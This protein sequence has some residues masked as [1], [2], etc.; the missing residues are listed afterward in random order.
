MQSLSPAFD[1]RR[2]WTVKV[3][4]ICLL[5]LLL[6]AIYWALDTHGSFSF[7]ERPGFLNYNML[8][9]SLL[10]GQVHLRQEVHPGRLKERDQANPT[11]PYPYMFDAIVFQ[12]KYYLHHLPFPALIHASW[13]A[14]AGYPLATGFMVVL[15]A[16]GC[17]VWLGLI[18]W[19]IR[20]TFFEQSPAWIL[21]FVL[22][23]FA[24]SGVQLYM[25]SR[26]VIYHEAIATG[27]FLALGGVA[28]C[29]LIMTSPSVNNLMACIAGLL[30]GA[31]IACRA[32]LVFYPL[33]FAAC[34]TAD[35]ILR[36]RTPAT[37]FKQ[38][39]SLLAPVAVSVGLLLLYNH[40][41]FGDFFYSGLRHVALPF[42]KVY[43]YCCL[44][45]NYFRLAHVPYHLYY[46]L[47]GVPDVALWGWFPYLS[48]PLDATV[49]NEVMVLREKV[50]S[51]FLLTP[52]LL[53]ILP[54]PGLLQHT[55]AGRHLI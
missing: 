19:R 10:A 49:L 50:G 4:W 20:Q 52:V 34:L 35:S 22:A 53:L 55:R 39:C 38:S 18:L 33:C 14:V 36:K 3:L 17:V 46:W 2:A 48:R 30:F 44:Q 16:L 11:L 21:W 27:V 24:L 1:V 54:V 31:A 15:A 26:P 32:T 8:A 23:S 51:I 29:I 25:V 6:L 45:G 42:P 5:C 7:G 13:T 40:A 47:L 28:V 41:R 9:E 43:E 12:G 37:I